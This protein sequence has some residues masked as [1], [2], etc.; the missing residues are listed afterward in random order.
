MLYVNAHFQDKEG[1]VSYGGWPLLWGVF[2]SAA[3]VLAAVH[4]CGMALR[5][6]KLAGLEGTRQASQAHHLL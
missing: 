4:E 2:G 5:D 6:G 3:E 1:D